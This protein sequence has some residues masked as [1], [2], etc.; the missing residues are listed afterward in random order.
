[1]AL[2]TNEPDKNGQP[3]RPQ[4]APIPAPAAPASE[5]VIESPQQMA[6]SQGSAYLDRG[7]K[8]TGKLHFEGPARI[9]GEVDGEIHGK[10]ITIG[11]SATVTAQITADSVIVCGKVKGEI[12]A[13]QRLEIRAT[14]KVQGN[15]TTPKLMIHEGAIFDG[16]CA[17]ESHGAH[18][19]KGA[20]R[21]GSHPDTAASA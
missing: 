2:F 7:T 4:T 20:P 1:M 8:I 5:R 13:S 11:E 16:Q 6:S 10:S 12:S 15:I 14:A 21:N 9:D 18:E 17:M 3:S 19:R